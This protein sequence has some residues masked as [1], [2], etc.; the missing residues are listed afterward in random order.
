[1]ATSKTDVTGGAPEGSGATRVNVSASEVTG[2]VGSSGSAVGTAIDSILKLLS[3]V[4]FG[5][6]MLGTLLTCCMIG[7]LIM[8]VSV[9][10]FQKYYSELSPAKRL[11]FGSLGFFDIY[12]AWY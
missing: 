6:V 3:S 11:V 5:L 1:M 8:Q 7:M 2:A 4:R 12:H 9:E 10:G